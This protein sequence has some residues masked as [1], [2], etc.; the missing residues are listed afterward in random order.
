MASTLDIFRL[1]IPEFEDSSDSV[2][3]TALELAL[4][5][6]DTSN[7]GEMLQQATVYMAAHI[8]KVS[9]DSRA[10]KMAGLIGSQFSSVKEENLSVNRMKGSDFS[11]SLESTIYGRE[12]LELRDRCVLPVA[13]Y[14]TYGQAPDES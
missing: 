10:E 13:G 1:L 12:Y 9:K 3:N 2:V 6:F 4:T 8:L 5:R 11:S 7:Y 14:S